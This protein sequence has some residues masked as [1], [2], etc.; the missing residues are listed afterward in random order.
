MSGTIFNDFRDISR[1]K[2]AKK[3]IAET[4]DDKYIAREVP[5]IKKF[6]NIC[7]TDCKNMTDNL[8][9]TISAHPELKT[10]GVQS[11]Q[12]FI[13]RI[14]LAYLANLFESLIMTLKNYG[15]KLT[16]GNVKI[17]YSLKYLK[18]KINDSKEHSFVNEKFKGQ[19]SFKGTSLKCNL[20]RYKF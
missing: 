14:I 13:S 4:Y 8:H 1:G 18:L 7:Y 9:S 20:Y 6:A 2:E 17:L 19:R 5:I 16:V 3:M 10:T 15:E 12:E 11:D